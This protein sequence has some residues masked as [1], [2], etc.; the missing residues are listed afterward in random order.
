MPT[1]L[2]FIYNMC[3]QKFVK[4]KQ[5]T[6]SE[7]AESTSKQY[8]F[9]WTVVIKVTGVLGCL[10][11]RGRRGYMPI[12]PRIKSVLRDRSEF[13]TRGGSS[14]PARPVKNETPPKEY[15]ASITGLYKNNGAVSCVGINFVIFYSLYSIHHRAHMHHGFTE[16]ASLIGFTHGQL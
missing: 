13:T 4:L 16:I 9:H 11:L 1:G 14:Q 8:V 6:A 10:N 7:R 15:V 3:C 2:K 5:S 12:V